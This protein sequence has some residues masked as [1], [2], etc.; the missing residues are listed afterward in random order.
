[1]ISFAF[2]MDTVECRVGAMLE[3]LEQRRVNISIPP[4]SYISHKE[5]T[6]LTSKFSISGIVGLRCVI[7]IIDIDHTNDSNEF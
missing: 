4:F 3:R 7:M 6:T 2:H 5:H 1:M